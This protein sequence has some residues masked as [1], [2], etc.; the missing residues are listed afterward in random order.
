[1]ISIPFSNPCWNCPS[2]KSKV[3]PLVPKMCP[4]SSKRLICGA[5][6]GLSYSRNSHEIVLVELPLPPRDGFPS[7]NLLPV[8]VPTIECERSLKI[9]LGARDVTH[10]TSISVTLTLYLNGP[11]P[12]TMD[13]MLPRY[14]FPCWFAWTLV[15][16]LNLGRDGAMVSVSGG[17]SDSVVDSW[18]LDCFWCC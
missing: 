18:C 1:M 8:L 12:G 7:R 2:P 13:R 17:C 3:I 14:R 9:L 10:I 4:D 16:G 15:P 11:V 5:G 6:S